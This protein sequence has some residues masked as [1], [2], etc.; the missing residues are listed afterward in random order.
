M[1]RALGTVL[2]VMVTIGYVLAGL[3]TVGVL[4][5][6]LWWPGLV[7]ASTVG[8]LAVLLAFLAPTFFIGFAIDA[9]LL[10]LVLAS[11]WTPAATLGVRGASG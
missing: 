11:T 2:V 7:A 1:I 5:P 10:A 9:A 3:A 8:S 4:V 6:V